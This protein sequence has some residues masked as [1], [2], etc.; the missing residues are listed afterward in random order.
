VQAA[1]GINLGPVAGA[2]SAG[3]ACTGATV[4][5]TDVGCTPPPAPASTG[6]SVSTGG[7]LLGDHTVT[8]P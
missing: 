5:S 8:L 3:D 4:A 7:S 2:L 1:V 6:L